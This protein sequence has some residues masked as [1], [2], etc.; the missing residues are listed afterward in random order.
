MSAGGSRVALVLGSGGIKC[1]ASVGLWRVMA[2][3]G[4]RPDLVVGCSGGSVFASAIATGMDPD[5]MEAASIDLWSRGLTGKPRLRSIMAAL[6]PKLFDFSEEFG[7]LD[8]RG[9]IKTF[10]EVFGETTITDTEI[11]LLITA[12]DTGN[13]DRVVLREG[14]IADAIRASIAI[15]VV[16]PPWRIGDRLLIDGG[17]SDPLPIGVAIQ[18]GCDVIIAMGFESPYRQRVGSL[19]QL[20]G[21]TTTITV[22]HLLESSFSFY[23]L[24]HHAELVPIMP[25][26]DRPLP[27]TDTSNMPYIIEV[28]AAATEEQIEYIKQLVNPAAEAS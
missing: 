15:P 21:Q 18:Q 1:A 9:A 14:R 24:V 6:F 11:P 16:L 27:V 19:A 25:E 22:N 12:T 3:E 4:L 17:A 13:G 7:L 8:D 28:G 26:F 20:I 10:V 5:T 23:N 2:R